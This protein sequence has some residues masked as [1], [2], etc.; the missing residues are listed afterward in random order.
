MISDDRTRVDVGRIRAWLAESH[1]ASDRSAESIEWDYTPS[2]FAALL[3]ELQHEDGGHGLGDRPDAVLHVAGRAGLDA[4]ERVQE[5]VQLV[6]D[7]VRRRVRC[8]SFRPRPT[9]PS[10]SGPPARGRS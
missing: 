5:D 8:P 1:W 6:Q 4:E 9:T 2:E 3:L 7:L 10:T